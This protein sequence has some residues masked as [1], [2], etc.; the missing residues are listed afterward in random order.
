MSRTDNERICT[1]AGICVKPIL[2]ANEFLALM[3][4][5]PQITIMTFGPEGR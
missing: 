3:G 1:I 5:S 4:Y 2:N